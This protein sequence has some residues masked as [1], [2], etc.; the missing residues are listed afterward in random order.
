MKL[1]VVDEDFLND[2]DD[3]SSHISEST[4]TSIIKNENERLSTHSRLDSV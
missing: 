3:M 1:D 4:L 2:T